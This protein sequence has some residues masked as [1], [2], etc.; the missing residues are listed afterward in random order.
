MPTNPSGPCAEPGCPHKAV[1]MGR[2]IEHAAALNQA[3]DRTYKPRSPKSRAVYKTKRWQIIRRA[4]LGR[5]D[6]QCVVDDCT[7][8]ATEVDH[9]TPMEQGGDPYDPANLQA[10]CK[11]HHS[12]KTMRE[13]MGRK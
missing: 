13:V 8:L 2:C 5:A 10:L 3:K 7:N 6:Y 4:I 12:R 1:K 9:I 11:R